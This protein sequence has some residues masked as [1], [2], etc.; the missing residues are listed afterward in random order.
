MRVPKISHPGQ[1]VADPRLGD[2]ALLH[3]QAAEVVGAVVQRHL[4]HGLALGD[5]GR[6]DVADIVEKNTAKI[7][8]LKLS[9]LEPW[10]LERLFEMPGEFWEWNITIV[11][12]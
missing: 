12:N 10:P 6:L 7:T 1:R 11:I 5:P 2:H 9:L 3:H 4:P 8:W